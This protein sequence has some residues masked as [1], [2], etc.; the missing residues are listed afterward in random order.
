MRKYFKRVIRQ[1]VLNRSVMTHWDLWKAQAIHMLEKRDDIPAVAAEV[2]HLQNARVAIMAVYQNGQLDANVQQLTRT[3][4][5]RGCDVVMINNGKL[6]A[7]AREACR[8]LFALYHERPSGRGRDFASYRVGFLSLLAAVSRQNVQPQELFFLNDSVLYVDQRMDTFLDDFFAMPGDWKGVTESSE[9][10]YH[11]S[12]WFFSVGKGIWRDVRFQK[13]WQDYRPLHSRPYVIARGEV[14]LST[15]LNRM[16]HFSTV[17]YP[18]S[19]FVDHVRTL[20]AGGLIELLPLMPVEYFQIYIK[21]YF[22]CCEANRCED[23]TALVIADIIC[24]QQRTNQS[25]FWQ[26]I[27]VLCVG[28]P[29]VKKDIYAKGV[30]GVTQLRQFTAMMVNDA[31][32]WEKIVRRICSTPDHRTIRGIRRLRK[33]YGID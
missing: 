7:E 2:R 6:T 1:H 5:R 9:P 14:G 10:S 20:G 33:E 16:G 30:F 19:R 29:F 21:K 22:S 31:V 4:M 32:D 26:L 25:A 12:S 23:V 24:E 13:Y 3:L 17:L 11:V 27:G 8:D 28:F 15:A 18:A